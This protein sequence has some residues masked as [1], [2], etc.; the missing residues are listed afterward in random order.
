MKNQSGFN[1]F[2]LVIVMSIVGIL[3]VIGVPSFQYVTTSNRITSEVN[4]LLGDLQFA[5]SEAIREGQYVT[6]CPS[7]NPLQSPPQCSGSNSWQTG[8]IVFI[9]AVPNQHVPA[10]PVILRLQ[11]TFTSTDTF[12]ADNNVQA[13]TFNRSGFA[14][15]GPI[16]GTSLIP[17]VTIA[18][19][20]ATNQSQWT[21]CVAVNTTSVNGVG[22][23]ATERPGTNN[24]S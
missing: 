19:H 21:R 5:R 15:S 16:G 14:M 11:N 4:G 20:D 7:A 6:V 10:N 22:L 18:L 13:I 17:Q 2:E 9:D 8:W 3:T 12:V 24:C 23:L 1:L